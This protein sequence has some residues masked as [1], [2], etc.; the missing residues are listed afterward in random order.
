M[1]NYLGP[2]TVTAAMKLMLSQRIAEDISFGFKV[3]TLR[4]DEI[5]TASDEV[6]INLF[7]Y[8]V[9][10][11][12]SWRNHDL[13]T[14]SGRGPLVQKARLAI[15]LHYLI[16]FSG[17]DG[18]LEP[19]KLM[20]ST[21][22]ILHQQPVLSR[23]WI[24]HAIKH[25]DYQGILMGADI[26]QEVE[27]VKFTAQPFSLEE[28][29][30]LW[31]IFL[32]TPY[33]LSVAYIASV[34]F[35]EA[36]EPVPRT[37]AVLGREVRVD[38]FIVLPPSPEPTALPGLIL[39]LR[40]DRGVAIDGDS[41]ELT[42]HDQSGSGRHARQD[43]AGRQPRHEAHGVGAFPVFHFDGV[44]DYLRLDWTLTG[45]VNALTAAALIHSPAGST[46][47]VISFDATAFWELQGPGADG[48]HPAW[49]STNGGSNT[50]TAGQ[51]LVDGRWHLVLV[52]YDPAAQTKRIYVDGVLNGEI[53]AHGGAIGGGGDR[54]G[55][56][57]VSAADN[58]AQDNTGGNFFHGD[59]AELIV[60]ARRLNT[61][62]RQQLERYLAGQYAHG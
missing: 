16:T 60:Y 58:P 11:N 38:P 23:S 7:L 37:R 8:Q 55:R 28:M 33:R 3:T 32:Q 24:D 56:I 34:V 53:A 35:V 10:P 4:P 52:E 36:Q 1:S 41:G 57:G 43:Q 39:W 50:L 2:A 44:D 62:E 30:K 48:L 54:A 17:K 42:W 40:S 20:A 5:P 9:T 25:A 22:H 46:G 45:A 15:D 21:L 31:S 49:I 13:P 47:S 61:E 26:G 29:S 59:L 51:P 27:Q 12:T 18:D 14:R 19:Q 6:S